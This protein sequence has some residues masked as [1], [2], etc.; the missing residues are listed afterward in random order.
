MRKKSVPKYVPDF[1]YNAET[2][3]THCL[4]RILDSKKTSCFQFS[5][6]GLQE[7]HRN[8]KQQ[9]NFNSRDG[10]FRKSS[11]C[12]FSCINPGFGGP[13]GMLWIF[14]LNGTFI[15]LQMNIFGQKKFSPRGFQT[16]L[17]ALDHIGPWPPGPP[18][19]GGPDCLLQLWCIWQSLRS[20]MSSKSILGFIDSVSNLCLTCQ[21]PK[22]LPLAL[23][24]SSTNESFFK[25]VCEWL[26]WIDSSFLI[27]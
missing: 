13:W 22:Q 10:F 16:F 3:N 27:T 20:F 1:M 12:T 21:P 7:I 6:P 8:L 19:S 9:K 18:D 15:M 5:I 14:F 25:Q 4:Y 24:L 26:T 23:T 11:F 17:I 2:P